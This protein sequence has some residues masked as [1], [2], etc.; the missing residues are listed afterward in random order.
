VGDPTPNPYYW[1]GIG[2]CLLVAG[3]A[4]YEVFRRRSS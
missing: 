1:G 4:S 3:I 2:L